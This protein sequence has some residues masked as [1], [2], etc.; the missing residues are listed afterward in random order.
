MVDNK[1]TNPSDRKQDFVH[2]AILLTIALGIGIY[3][4]TTT[5]LIAKDGVFHIERAQQFPSNPVGIIKA[6]PP[7]YPVLIFLAH[8]LVALFSNGSSVQTWIY[9]AQG[10]SLLCRILSLIPLYFIGKM[11]VGARSSFWA[12]L[13]LIM[14]PYP[15][16][17]GSDVLRDWPHILFLAAGFLFLLWG[18]K[19]GKWWM[20]VIVGLAGGLGHII[21]AECAQVV[22]YGVLWLLVSLFIPRP[23][24]S[25]LKAICLTLILLIGFAIPATPYMKTRGRILSPKL[26]RVISCNTPRQSSRPEQSDFNG[27]VAAYTASGVPADILKAIGRL[28]GEISDNLMYFF[29]PALL[30][31]VYYCLCKQ[32]AGTEVERFFMTVFIVFNV[33]MMVLLHYNYGYISRRHCL[34]LV[35]FTIF[36]VPIGLQISADWLRSKSYKGQLQANQNPQ[37]WF[38]ILLAVGAVICLPKLVNP[39]RTEKQGYRDAS[40]WLKGNTTSE[41][42]IAVPDKRICFYA[43]RKAL[44]YEKKVPKQAKYIVRIVKDE[45][46]EFGRIVQEKYSLWV[47]ERKKK[48]KLCIYKIE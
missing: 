45:K 34:P 20:F 46:P 23:N 37:L 11:L 29:V 22:I 6:H 32:S 39:M 44:V 28:S 16:E 7:G 14:L 41:D 21:R 48:K 10:V 30:I 42:I 40:V 27:T 8:K 26:K 2:V 31:G 13:I 25:R 15:A 3:L 47:D 36:Y 24:I 4:I 33:I 12:I 1:E 17:F 38:F 9:S 19:Q 18:A 5:V 43:E 35:V